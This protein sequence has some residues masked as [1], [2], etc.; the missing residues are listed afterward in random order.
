LLRE[1]RLVSRPGSA[2]LTA[3]HGG[4]DEEFGESISRRRQTVRTRLPLVLSATALCVTLLGSTPL[5]HAVVEALPANSVGTKQLKDKSVTS[6]KLKPGAVSGTHVLDGSLLASDFKTG[7][8]PAGPQGP[9]GPSG[10]KGDQGPAGPPGLSGLQWVIAATPNDSTSPKVVDATCPAGKKVVGGGHQLGGT[11]PDNVTAHWSWP[12]DDLSKFR[13]YGKWPSGV[14][15]SSW[16]LVAYAVCATV[17][18]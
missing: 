5:G 8:L 11:G 3:H 15:P 10:P 12:W 9:A 6:A 7:Q 13:A 1:R 2:A 18:P 14:F 16:Q 17:A 4:E